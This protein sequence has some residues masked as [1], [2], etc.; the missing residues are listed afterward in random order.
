MCRVYRSL[1]EA[2]QMKHVCEYSIPD[3][4]AGQS[5][6]HTSPSIMSTQNTKQTRTRPE[7][8]PL[9]PLTKHQAMPPTP[10]GSIS[11][12]PFPHAMPYNLQGSGCG[13]RDIEYDAFEVDLSLENIQPMKRRRRMLWFVCTICL[14]LTVI[15]GACLVLTGDYGRW[16]RG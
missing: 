6:N 1:I 4:P 5:N 3:L 14:G 11:L 10:F 8:Q 16:F 2:N 9:L 12:R 15:T 7:Q 13:W